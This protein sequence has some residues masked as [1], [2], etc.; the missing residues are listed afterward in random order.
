MLRSR[1]ANVLL[2]SIVFATSWLVSEYLIGSTMVVRG[3][4]MHPYL[5]SGDRIWTADCS[6][7][8]CTI[9]RGSVVI[10]RRLVDSAGSV[11][12]R[13][14]AL[15]GDTIVVAEG[16]YFVNRELVYSS[17]VSLHHDAL[18][19][20]WHWRYVAGDTSNYAPDGNNWGPIIIPAGEVFVLGD[21]LPA[22]GD[23][24]KSGP[25]PSAYIESKVIGILPV[26]RILSLLH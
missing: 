22:S 13:V 21:N 5:F 2:L 4:S 23:S 7:E 25:V 20:S 10:I 24:R 11:V 6:D 3:I 16:R 26:G 14:V 18:S 1:A 12:K 8:N 17:D 15:S 9:S 19:P